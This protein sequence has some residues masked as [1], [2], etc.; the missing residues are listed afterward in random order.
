M[1]CRC[2]ITVQSGWK[3]VIRPSLAKEHQHLPN[4]MLQKLQI[5][6]A[7]WSKKITI[8]FSIHKSFW[9]NLHVTQ[10]QN[11][12]AHSNQ[13]IASYTQAK[14]ML[15]A[16]QMKYAL[17]TTWSSAESQKCLEVVLLTCGGSVFLTPKAKRPPKL[18]TVSLL[19][20]TKQGPIL[21]MSRLQTN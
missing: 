16:E 14:K 1:N 7:I 10:N 4:Q 18:P 6:S 12:S 11:E 3:I 9:L 15:R 20:K 21:I 5:M 8:Y 2:T 19:T 17:K 13:N